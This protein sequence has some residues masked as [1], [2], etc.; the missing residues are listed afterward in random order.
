MST[1]QPASWWVYLLRCADNSLYTGISNNPTRRW[2]QHNAGTASRYTRSRLPV[3]P[4]YC[5][6]SPSHSDALKRE[7]AI[8]QLSRAEKEA[9]LAA[10]G[11][12]VLPD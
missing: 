2:Q 9:L 8:K 4:V 12:L 7:H 11:P 1:D 3:T 5:E 10:A 6:A